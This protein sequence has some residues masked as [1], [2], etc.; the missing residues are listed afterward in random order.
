MKK[1]K[2]GCGCEKCKWMKKNSYAENFDAKNLYDSIMFRSKKPFKVSFSEGIDV[3]WGK[4]QLNEKKLTKK[5]K[6][7]KEEMVMKLK[8]KMKDFKGRYGK[9]AKQVIYATATKHAKKKP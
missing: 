4:E 8:G 1:N 3:S 6:K 9:R 2:K 7:Q 5:D